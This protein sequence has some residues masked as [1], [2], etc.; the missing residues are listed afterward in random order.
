M[1]PMPGSSARRSHQVYPVASGPRRNG[2]GL[3]P[4][5]HAYCT[6]FLATTKQSAPSRRIGTCGL[7]VGTAWNAS[8]GRRRLGSHIPSLLTTATCGRLRS[9][10]H[11]GTQRAL[12]HLPYCNGLVQTDSR[13]I[14]PSRKSGLRE[15]H[16]SGEGN[17]VR[18]LRE[19]W[20]SSVIR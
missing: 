19:S 6:R 15:Q 5:L 8:S 10:A 12:L 18:R 7:A 13:L 2:D 1:P 20:R 11:R 9:A 17:Q 14:L 3:L 4:W 16:R